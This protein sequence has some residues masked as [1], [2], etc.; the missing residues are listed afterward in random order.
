MPSESSQPRR[1]IALLALH[2]G[3]G[4][5]AGIAIGAIAVLADVWHLREL[6]VST[7]EP[8]VPLAFLLANSGATGAVAKVAVFV[9]SFGGDEADK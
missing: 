1:F 6:L 2:A 8:Y 7:G 4:F 9:L 5:F 3:L